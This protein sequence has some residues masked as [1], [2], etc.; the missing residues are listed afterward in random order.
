[1]KKILF[2][3]E[4]DR[5]EVLNEIN[6]NLE[7]K[8]RLLKLILL[9]PDKKVSKNI[10]REKQFRYENQIALLERI[11]GMVITCNSRQQINEINKLIEYYQSLS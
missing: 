9:N 5:K 11:K 4:N 2:L 8:N 6:A 7:T 10:T 1:M 3:Q